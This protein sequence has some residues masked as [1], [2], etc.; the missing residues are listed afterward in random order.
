MTKKSTR[1]TADAAASH[2]RAGRK[3]GQERKSATAAPSNEVSHSPEGKRN[4]NASVPLRRQKRSHAAASPDRTKRS[5]AYD[6]TITPVAR[7]NSK[8]AIC[9]KLLNRAE[10]A[11]IEELMQATGWQGHSVRGFLSGEVRKRMELG[12]ASTVTNAGER[13]YHIANAAA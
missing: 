3:P 12:L 13:R 7:H 1:K 6:A 2:G 11:S 9:L 5:P 8:K 10:G 4:S